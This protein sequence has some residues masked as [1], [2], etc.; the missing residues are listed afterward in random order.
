MEFVA[1]REQLGQGI[2]PSL[3]LRD[4]VACRNLNQSKRW[5]T[6]IGRSCVCIT[7]SRKDLLLPSGA[8]VTADSNHSCVKANQL[9]SHLCKQLSHRDDEDPYNPVQPCQAKFQESVWRLIKRITSYDPWTTGVKW[10]T[11]ALLLTVT[12]PTA[13]SLFA[14]TRIRTAPE[15]LSS[16]GVS[17]A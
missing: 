7:Q 1:R 15:L 9:L 14:R 11:P 16:T 2:R 5:S 17:R 12:K 6:Y 3:Q 8:I 10:T 13:S 4:Q